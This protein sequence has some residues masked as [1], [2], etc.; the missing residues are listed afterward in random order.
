MICKT[1]PNFS[2]L[3]LLMHGHDGPAS[4]P[5]SGSPSAV[6][7]SPLAVDLITDLPFLPGLKMSIRP[8]IQNSLTP[9]K[10]MYGRL[11]LLT[12]RP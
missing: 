8:R 2:R 10:L 3:G 11:G 7:F 9:K 5:S 12:N 4:P 1:A 6:C